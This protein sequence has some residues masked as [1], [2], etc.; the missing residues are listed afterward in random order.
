MSPLLLQEMR[1]RSDKSRALGPTDQLSRVPP[2]CASD[3]QRPRKVSSEKNTVVLLL[4]F[5]G[6]E[7]GVGN[8]EV[9]NMW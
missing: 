6:R 2:K 1:G 7:Q 8:T 4:M 9:F 5:V 3:G